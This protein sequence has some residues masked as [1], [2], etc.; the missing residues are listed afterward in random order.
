MEFRHLQGL[1]LSSS[2]SEGQVTLT[3]KTW[4]LILGCVQSCP[5]LQILCVKADYNSTT[6][7]LAN[8]VDRS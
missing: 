8:N 2:N 3:P 1:L 7:V 6:K 5:A 4:R